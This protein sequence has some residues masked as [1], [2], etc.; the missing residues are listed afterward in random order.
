MNFEKYQ[1]NE[2]YKQMVLK[3]QIAIY[4]KA[5]TGKSTTS[6]NISAALSHMDEKVMQIGCDPKRD[7]IATLCGKLMPT[8]LGMQQK[9]KNMNEEDIMNLVFEGYNGV[10]GM[11]SGGPLP[12]RG[13][14][15]K[16]TD[17]ALKMIQRFK[18]FEKFGVT[19]ALF[20][21][22]GDVVCGGF[23]VPIR[24]GFAKEMYMITCGEIL[25]MYQANSII[26][27]VVR[28]RERGVDVGV[29]GFINNMRGVPN[30]KAVVEDFANEVGV[31][32]I[33]H[34]PRSKL[35]QNA[36]FQGKTII[37]CF[38]DSDQADV[39]RKL[40]KDVLENDQV[41]LPNTVSLSK[42]KEIVPEY[43]SKAGAGHPPSFPLVTDY[44][45]TSKANK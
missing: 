42:L 18:I 26:Q 40:A 25:T 15:G 36:E 43:D 14:A 30:E 7:S 32:V 35:V 11:E 38:P 20:D 22:L 44:G 16:G 10:L 1:E 4:G 33:G 23:S 9:R 8:I 19:F 29:G 28:L 45:A 31:P 5:G 6:S 37:E 12:G 2:G 21:V 27:A 13:C 41:Y 3:K 17:L 39:Y 24:S 34:V